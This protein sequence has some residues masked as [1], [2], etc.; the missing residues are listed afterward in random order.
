MKCACGIIWLTDTSFKRT[1]DTMYQNGARNIR[2]I[3]IIREIVSPVVCNLILC[4]AI[5]YIVLMGIIKHLGTF[6]T[7]VQVHK[8]VMC[9]WCVQCIYQ[10]IVHV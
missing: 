5:P 7:V 9:V 2:L 10:P 4:L 1:L 8:H 3:F 6:H